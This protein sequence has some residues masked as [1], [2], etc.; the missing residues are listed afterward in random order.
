MGLPVEMDLGG[1][2]KLANN[3]T[4]AVGLF[5]RLWAFSLRG[6]VNN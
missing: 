4:Q 3:V 6:P 2:T 5:I 1:R